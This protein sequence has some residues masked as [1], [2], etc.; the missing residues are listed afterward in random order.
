[1][2]L[3][4]FLWIGLFVLVIVFVSMFDVVGFGVGEVLI[5]VCRVCLIYGVV[6]IL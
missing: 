4:S 1:M 5:M 3:V 2:G 6:I